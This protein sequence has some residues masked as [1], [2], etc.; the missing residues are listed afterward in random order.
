ML[1]SNYENDYNKQAEISKKNKIITLL[2]LMFFWFLGFHRLY[3]GSKNLCIAHLILTFIILIGFLLNIEESKIVGI[4]ALVIQ[5]VW[6][7]IELIM[8][9]KG[10]LKDG[11]KKLI[12]K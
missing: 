1:M 4:V 9:I 6:C 8:I 7:A 12:L 5:I 10:K 3:T 11:E 2:L